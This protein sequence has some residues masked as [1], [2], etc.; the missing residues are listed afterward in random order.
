MAFTGE[1]GAPTHEAGGLL[2]IVFSNIPFTYTQIDDSLFT[3]SDYFTLITYLPTAGD[4]RPEPVNYAVRDD[5]LADFGKLV[6]F[7]IFLLPDPGAAVDGAALNAWVA[8]FEGIWKLALK[9]GGIPAS[10]RGRAAPWW[11]REY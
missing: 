10:K 4:L 7:G 6:E 5:K 8:A 11:T 9:A 3:E 2:D 1:I